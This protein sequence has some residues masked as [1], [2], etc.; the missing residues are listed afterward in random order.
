MSTD[1]YEAAHESIEEIIVKMKPLKSRYKT[2][3]K[4]FL[5]GNITN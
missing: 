3:L 2:K 5:W 4:K 1:L